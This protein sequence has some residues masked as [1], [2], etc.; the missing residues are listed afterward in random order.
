MA[1][2]RGVTPSRETVETILGN[3]LRAR[4]ELGEQVLTSTDPFRSQ[5]PEK[6]AASLHDK[7]WLN[8]A[9]GEI[10]SGLLGEL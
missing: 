1:G 8:D 3:L 7:V 9:L 6:G 5:N 4:R 2:F 10:F